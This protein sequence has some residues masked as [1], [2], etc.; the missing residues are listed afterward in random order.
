[1]PPQGGNFFVH[2]FPSKK[3]LPEK[4]PTQKSRSSIAGRVPPNF[5]DNSNRKVNEKIAQ[6]EISWRLEIRKKVGGCAAGRR[7]LDSL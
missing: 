4:H 5:P 3:Y 1:M 6:K 7:S 2:K